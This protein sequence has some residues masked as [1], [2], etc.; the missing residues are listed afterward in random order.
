MCRIFFRITLDKNRC[1]SVCRESG[2]DI[3]RG[4]IQ[5]IL[6]RGRARLGGDAAAGKGAP[7]S[8]RKNP[9]QIRAW[10]S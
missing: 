4:V 2:V 7:G 10:G 9:K 5:L 3:F 6:P 8:K 1:E